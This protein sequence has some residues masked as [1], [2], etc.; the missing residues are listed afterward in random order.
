MSAPPALTVI[1]LG[2]RVQSSVMILMSAEGAFDRVS[3]SGVLCG[4]TLSRKPSPERKPV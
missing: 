1:S 2:G 3:D 4:R